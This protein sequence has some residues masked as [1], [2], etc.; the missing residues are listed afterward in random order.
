VPSTLA[1]WDNR[2]ALIGVY[3]PN[4]AAFEFERLKPRCSLQRR[5]ACFL[6]FILIVVVRLARH[7]VACL[8]LA[9]CCIVVLV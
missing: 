5:F 6:Q 3:E 4:A 1:D 8:A 9:S 7:V 2:Y